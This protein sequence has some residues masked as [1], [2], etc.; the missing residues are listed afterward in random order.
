MMRISIVIL[1]LIIFNV[2][3]NFRSETPDEYNSSMVKLYSNQLLVAIAYVESELNPT[4]YLKRED[5]VGILQIRPIMVKDVNRILKLNGDTN[6]FNMKDRWDISKSID[7]FNI[8]TNFYSKS[9]SNVENIARRWN[10]GPTGH[11]K[12]STIHYWKQVKLALQEQWDLPDYS[13]NM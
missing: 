8:Y 2:R 1:I 10:G 12:S 7:I 5:A 3:T 9:L 4:A 13:T 11:H 6:R